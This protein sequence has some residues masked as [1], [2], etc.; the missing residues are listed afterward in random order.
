MDLTKVKK[1]K[2]HNNSKIVYNL[3]LKFICQSNKCKVKQSNY[4]STIYIALSIYTQLSDDNLEIKNNKLN[5]C[6]N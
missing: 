4:K 2:R 6:T 5:K 1:H 3:L